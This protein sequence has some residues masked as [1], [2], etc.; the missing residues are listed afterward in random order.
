MMGHAAMKLMASKR[1]RRWAKARITERCGRRAGSI[2]ARGCR[3][4]E[5]PPVLCRPGPSG[6][7][8]APVHTDLPPLKI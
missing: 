6:K 5:A 7:Y 4:L 8:G 3:P 1:V 2:E